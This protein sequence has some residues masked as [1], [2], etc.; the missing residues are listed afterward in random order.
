M[1]RYLVETYLA[2][3]ATAERTAQ[4]RARSGRA[5]SWRGDRS[6]SAST[7]RSM[8]RRTRSASSSSTRPRAGTR[9][10][11]PSGPELDPVSRRRSD[12][13]PEG[14]DM[15][16]KASFPLEPLVVV[17]GLL[18]AAATGQR[19]RWRRRR[20]PYGAGIPP[21][22]A[23]LTWNTYAVNAVRA[24]TPTKFQT[25][26]MVYMAYVQAAVYDA[27]T[28]IDGK[29]EP[30]HDFAFTAGARRLRAGCG[31]GCGPHVLNNYLPDQ[32][33]TVDAEYNAYLATLTRR[34]RRRR[35]RRQRG[36][37]RSDRVQDR[38]R[39]QGRDPGLRAD[40]S[41]H[42]GQVA[43]AVGDADGPDAVARHDAPVPARRGVAVP[44]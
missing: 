16:R 29:Y 32:Q 19:W 7:A 8:F 38:R 17:V 1:K 22:D 6:A 20:I 25:D 18:A 35:R 24:S 5:R 9:R 43:V 12:L 41:D 21:P 14:G 40:R 3:G 42:P 13:V 31:R 4:D 2:R 33:P 11:S 26:G 28:K 37:K 23:V 27:V 34:C 36:G 39:A 15:K 44:G 10:W 30:Y